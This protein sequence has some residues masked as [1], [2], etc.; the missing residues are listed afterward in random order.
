[1]LYYLGSFRF[2]GCCR[3]AFP[4]DEPASGPFC[5]RGPPSDPPL[6]GTNNTHQCHPGFTTSESSAK[7]FRPIVFWQYQG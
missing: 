6:A 1:M 2:C 7:P 5:L 4:Q 3:R